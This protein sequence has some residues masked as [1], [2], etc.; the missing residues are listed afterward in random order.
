M[1]AGLRVDGM[2]GHENEDLA[3]NAFL[4]PTLQSTTLLAVE[5]ARFD[6]RRSFFSKAHTRRES[7]WRSDD[8]ESF[9]LQRKRLVLANTW[10]PNGVTYLAVNSFLPHTCQSTTLLAVHDVADFLHS[11]IGSA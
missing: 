10:Q 8:F 4:P 7:F 5:P 6:R 9:S 3:L 11:A 2:T 1:E